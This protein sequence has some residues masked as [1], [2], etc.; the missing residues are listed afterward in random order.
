P[1]VVYNHTGFV[2][3]LPFIEQG[4]LFKQYN[5]QYVSSNSSPYG[6]ATGQDPGGNPNRVVASKTLAI[7]TRPSDTNHPPNIS[8]TPGPPTPAPTPATR[9]SA[10]SSPAATTCP[11]PAATPTT[12]PPGRKRLPPSGAPS[13][14]TGPS[15]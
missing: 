4:N 3:L 15:P 9:T 10:Q 14:T 1:Y 12:T 11:A 6:I 5:Y 2:A 13:A 7:Y 8:P